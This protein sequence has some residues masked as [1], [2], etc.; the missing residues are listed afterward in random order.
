M[1]V[2][3]CGVS[4]KVSKYA[5]ENDKKEVQQ[6]F[7]KYLV[8][9]ES[10]GDFETWGEYFNY[11]NFFLTRQHIRTLQVFL[12]A[13][14]APRSSPQHCDVDNGSI[15]AMREYL[16]SIPKH[17]RQEIRRSDVFYI[18]YNGESLW[19]LV[20]EVHPDISI[21]QL[22]NLNDIPRQFTILEEFP[23]GYFNT[24]GTYNC[25][26][27]ENVFT[28]RIWDIVHY[29]DET[30]MQMKKFRNSISLYYNIITH[31]NINYLIIFNEDN[32]RDTDF[33]FEEPMSENNV[34]YQGSHWDNEMLNFFARQILCAKEKQGKLKNYL[35]HQTTL[36]IYKVCGSLMMD[37]VLMITAFMQVCY[38]DCH[39]QDPDQKT[40]VGCPGDLC[41][42]GC[43]GC[44]STKDHVCERCGTL[45]CEDHSESC[46][47][48]CKIICAE[49]DMV[50][51]LCKR[52]ICSTCVVFR[53]KCGECDCR[54]CQMCLQKC[55]SCDIY[56]CKSKKC[57]VV[58]IVCEKVHCKQ[59][60]K[61]QCIVFKRK[62]NVAM[63][64]TKKLKI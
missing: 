17:Q 21:Q 44:T 22:T 57:Y 53:S 30:Q 33:G 2:S 15:G 49:C 56:I 14:H 6:S 36:E 50:Q 61:N 34:I 47:V 64:I 45:A 12:K 60:S 8:N 52:R 38:H 4:S 20:N 28:F 19:F 5:T 43:F 39:K 11:L 41:S 25:F 51:C 27:F 3:T 37:I 46:D 31:Q 48:C 29:W 16:H 59:C 40:I 62:Q 63:N 18:D 7:G 32:P 54:F 13:R 24:L 42:F 55:E 23:I 1:L 10:K 58:C 9:A 26:S 35:P